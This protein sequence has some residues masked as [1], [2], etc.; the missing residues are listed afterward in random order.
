MT[1]VDNLEVRGELCPA[2][3]RQLSSKSF[4]PAADQPDA[5]VC[6]LLSCDF[7]HEHA[8]LYDSPQ[9]PKFA[10]FKVGDR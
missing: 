10:A 6:R 5:N 1:L 2:L 9:M 8:C 7:S 3:I 4:R